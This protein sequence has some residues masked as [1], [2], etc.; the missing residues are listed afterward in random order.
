MNITLGKSNDGGYSNTKIHVF[1][2]GS[3]H[4]LKGVFAQNS[5]QLKTTA[6]IVRFAE[7]NNLTISFNR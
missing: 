1:H 5:E 6:D 2:D 3:V 7:R 4:S